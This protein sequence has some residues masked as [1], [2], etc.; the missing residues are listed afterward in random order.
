[1]KLV[2]IDRKTLTRCPGYYGSTKNL[3]IL[4]EF[5]N[6]ELDCAEVKNFPHK[7]CNSCQTSI[8]TSIKRFNMTS[9]VNVITR[10][11]KVF[12]IKL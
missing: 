3:E 10:E 7:T 6:S 2:P 4:E 5:I 9:R 11:G 8:K 12:L 1:M